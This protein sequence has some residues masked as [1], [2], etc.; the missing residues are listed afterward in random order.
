MSN[1]TN[2]TEGSFK[3]KDPDNSNENY[4]MAKE[5]EAILGDEVEYT[6]RIDGTV[7][8]GDFNVMGFYGVLLRPVFFKYIKLLESADV[9]ETTVFPGDDSF[10]LDALIEEAEE[11]A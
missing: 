10:D 1:H 4:A 2:Y 6:E 9:W 7:V 11:G 5:I 3:F 8:S